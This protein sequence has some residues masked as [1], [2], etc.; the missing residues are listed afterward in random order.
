MAKG[1]QILTFIS[2]VR[3]DVLYLLQCFV[4]Y[5]LYILTLFDE[6]ISIVIHEHWKLEVA[7]A[8][9]RA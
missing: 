6:Y 9:K 4:Y 2:N 1:M 8:E 5:L 3:I 7:T